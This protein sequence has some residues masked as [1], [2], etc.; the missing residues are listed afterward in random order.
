MYIWNTSNI[1]SLGFHLQFYQEVKKAKEEFFKIFESATNGLI[2]TVENFYIEGIALFLLVLVHFHT[3]GQKYID[4]TVRLT[5]LD[6][7]LQIKFLFM[8]ALGIMPT[9]FLQ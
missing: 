6:H 7:S 1:Y 9:A 4:R 3:L 2:K 5:T 8:F